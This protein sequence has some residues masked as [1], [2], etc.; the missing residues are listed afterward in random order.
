MGGD[1]NKIR[2]AVISPEKPQV[3]VFPTEGTTPQAT[4]E[5]IKSAGLWFSDE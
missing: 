3:I 5:L 4:K 1:P 2:E